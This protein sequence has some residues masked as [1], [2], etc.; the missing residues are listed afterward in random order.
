MWVLYQGFGICFQPQLII[1]TSQRLYQKYRCEFDE[2]CA[3]Y[4]FEQSK[5]N[6][7]LHSSTD[8]GFEHTRGKQ[9]GVKK[10]DYSLSLPEI[11]LCFEKNRQKRCKREPKCQHVDCLRKALKLISWSAKSSKHFEVSLSWQISVFKRCTI[12]SLRWASFQIDALMP[13][14]YWLIFEI[15]LWESAW[16]S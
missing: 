13:A 8:K 14:S 6:C 3:G 5:F 12:T 7:I 15:R 1:F 2:K 16:D 9:T 10:S 11:S 4:T